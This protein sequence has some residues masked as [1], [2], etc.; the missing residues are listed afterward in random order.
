M[1]DSCE[2]PVFSEE[3]PFRVLD[4]RGTDPWPPVEEWIEYL[5]LGEVR[6]I[7]EEKP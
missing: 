1:P 6:S 5:R 3:W 2:V 4:W 7:M